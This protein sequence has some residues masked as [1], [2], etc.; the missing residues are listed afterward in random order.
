MS[1]LAPSAK[2][3][4]TRIWF[5]FLGGA[6]AWTFHLVACSLTAEWMGF[7]SID[8]Q[9][10]GIHIVAWLAIVWTVLATAIAGAAT[11]IAYRQWRQPNHSQSEVEG[12]TNSTAEFLART[13]T[14]SSGMFL[15]IIVVE[16]I[17]ILFY[18][19]GAV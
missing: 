13:G 14:I 3:E 8:R 10:L 4:K 18:L 11:Y 5:G 1:P 12:D 9:F 6:A 16:S 19:Q 17:P 7:A 2:I 15:L